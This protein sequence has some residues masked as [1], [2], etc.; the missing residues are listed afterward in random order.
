MALLASSWCHGF[1]YTPTFKL[2]S[3]ISQLVTHDG[4][5]CYTVM[6]GYPRSGLGLFGNQPGVN[7]AVQAPKQEAR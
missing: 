5:R 6:H 4:T 1:T 2:C 7:H 3:N